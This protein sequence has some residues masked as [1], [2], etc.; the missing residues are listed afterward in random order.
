MLASFDVTRIS[1]LTEDGGSR[2]SALELLHVIAT[3]I[4]RELDSRLQAEQQRLRS[5]EFSRR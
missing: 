3:S 1:A 4:E 5:S 2:P